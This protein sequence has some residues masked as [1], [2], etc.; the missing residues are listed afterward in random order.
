MGLGSEAM[1]ATLDK[2]ME[3]GKPMNK[4]VL[5]QEETSELLEETGQWVQC[6]SCSARAMVKVSLS[7]GELWFCLHHYNKNAE[8]LTN[9]GGIAKLLNITN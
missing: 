1:G 6:D 4:Q 2:A 7:F 9:K 8:A 3:M 5:V